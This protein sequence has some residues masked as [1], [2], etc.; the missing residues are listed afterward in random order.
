MSQKRENLLNGILH[1]LQPEANKGL[2]VNVDT[3]LLADFA[4]PAKREKILDIGCAH[5]A[6]SLILAKRGFNIV[7]LDIQQHLIEMATENAKINELDDKTKFITG[8]IK[9]YKKLWEAQSFD[10]IVVN[11]PYYETENS[12]KSPFEEKAKATQETN[13]TLEDVIMAS[14]YLLKNKGHLNIIISASRL[15]EL[16]ILLDKYNIA[17]KVMRSVHPKPN[18]SASVVLVEGMRAAKKGI[19]VLP[20][21][22]ICGSDGKETFELSSAY[23]LEGSEKL[24]L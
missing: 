8:D 6:I 15:V 11:P 17:A 20:P 2:R 19:T 18:T 16:F 5:G 4:K 22:F 7:G 23:T 3:I 13:C 10:R 1:I 9:D 14:K 21:L 12:Q 24:C